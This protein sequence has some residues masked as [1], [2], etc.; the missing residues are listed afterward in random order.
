[1]LAYQDEDF[2][3]K[4]LN[5]KIPIGE[6]EVVKLEKKQ[7]AKKKTPKKTVLNNSA[8]EALKFKSKE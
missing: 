2:D 5:R 6:K 3:E 4:I 8:Y 7:A 1:M